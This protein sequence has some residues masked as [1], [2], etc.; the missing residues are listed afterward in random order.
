MTSSSPGASYKHMAA[1]RRF[2][3]FDF[4]T[5][6][7]ARKT[8]A[9]KTIHNMLDHDP[10]YLRPESR[11]DMHPRIR[12]LYASAG[13]R[14]RKEESPPQ[15][16]QPLPR[17]PFADVP[18]EVKVEPGTGAANVN[19]MDDQDIGAPFSNWK[20]LHGLPE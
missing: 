19:E 2:V 7:P 12:W 9:Q 8:S 1:T 18:E 16:P 17:V 20:G 3:R 10:R 13:R 14:R 11:D 4:P 6:P 5:H 15:Q